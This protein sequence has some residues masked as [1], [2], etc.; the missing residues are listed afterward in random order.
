MLPSTSVPLGVVPDAHFPIGEPTTL[1][2][3]DIVVL[4]TDGLLEMT[5]A[6]EVPFGRDR[7]LQVVA[8]EREKPAGTIIAALYEAATQFS[9]GKKF[10][11]DITVVVIKVQPGD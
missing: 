10:S 6:E 4:F 9:A 3:G 1:Q 5:S 7:V 8:R 11:D 2:P